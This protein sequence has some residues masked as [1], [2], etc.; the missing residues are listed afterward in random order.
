MRNQQSIMRN[1]LTIILLF[2]SLVSSIN[3]HSFINMH[4]SPLAQNTQKCIYSGLE[5]NS[6]RDY[7]SNIIYSNPLGRDLKLPVDRLAH[8]I[9]ERSLM[10]K[11]EEGEL[12]SIRCEKC[13]KLISY[14]NVLEYVKSVVR[15]VNVKATVEVA[16]SA[17]EVAKSAVKVSAVKVSDVKVNDVKV[18]DVKV[19]VKAVKV[20]VKV[21][22]DAN[23]EAVKVNANDEAVKVQSDSTAKESTTAS[24]STAKESTTASESTTTIQSNTTIQST[25]N[26]LAVK[27]FPA[28]LK[29]VR[30]LTFVYCLKYSKPEELTAFLEYFRRYFKTRPYRAIRRKLDKLEEI[31][32][33]ISGTRV[34]AEQW[35]PRATDENLN[36]LNE[37]WNGRDNE[38]KDIEESVNETVENDNG[39][40]KNEKETANEIGN[41]KS[42]EEKNQEILFYSHS[43][44]IP[45]GKPTVDE[46]LVAYLGSFSDSSSFL[47]S[48]SDSSPSGSS[49]SSQFHTPPPHSFTC[50]APLKSQAKINFVNAKLL[51]LVNQPYISH[52]VKFAY[53]LPYYLNLVPERYQLTLIR[54]YMEEFRNPALLKHV[55]EAGNYAAAAFIKSGAESYSFCELMILTVV[56]YAFIPVNK[57]IIY[58][59]I[60]DYVNSPEFNLSTLIDA[61]GYCQDYVKEKDGK[62]DNVN[63]GNWNVSDKNGNY[64]KGDNVSDNVSVKN[65][66]DNGKG[67]DN[68]DSRNE[69]YRIIFEYIVETVTEILSLSDDFDFSCDDLRRI[70]E[71]N[72]EALSPGLERNFKKM[73]FRCI[74]DW[75]SARAS[76]IKMPFS[77]SLQ[78]LNQRESLETLETLKTESLSQRESPSLQTPSLTKSLKM[79]PKIKTILN[80][81]IA[82]NSVEK[83]CDAVAVFGD[84]CL[85]ESKKELFLLIL[86]L[87]PLS[88]LRL[89][90]LT[91]F[92]IFDVAEFHFL[93]FTSGNLSRNDNSRN[94]SRNDNSRNLNRNHPSGN[95][96]LS[97]NL[98]RNLNSDNKDP[99]FTEF[100]KSDPGR[101]YAYLAGLFSHLMTLQFTDDNQKLFLTDIGVIRPFK[102]VMKELEN[103]RAGSG[104]CRS[105]DYEDSRSKDCEDCRSK[106]CE[107][108]RFYNGSRPRPCSCNG[109]GKD[110]KDSSPIHS[111][112]SP[113][114][115]PTSPSTFGNDEITNPDALLAY[116][117]ILFINNVIFQQCSNK[118][119]LI[120]DLPP[121]R[122]KTLNR[123]VQCLLELIMNFDHTHR[124]ILT[125]QR[126]ILILHSLVV[127]LHDLSTD[128]RFSDKELIG[129]TKEQA[130]IILNKLIWAKIKPDKILTPYLYRSTSLESFQNEIIFRNF[131]VNYVNI[132]REWLLDGKGKKRELERGGVGNERVS[133]SEL[134]GEG[135][136]ELEGELER[137]LMKQANELKEH[138]KELI[139]QANE[140]MSHSNE[141]MKQAN[142]LMKQANELTE[143]ERKLKNQN[144]EL[145]NQNKELKEQNELKNKQ[146]ELNQS[147][148]GNKIDE[149]LSLYKK[150]GTIKKKTT[151]KELRDLLNEVITTLIEADNEP[152]T[153]LIETD[154]GP[155][156][157]PGVD[158]EP[159]IFPEGPLQKLN[160]FL[161]KV[162][163]RGIEIKRTRGTRGAKGMRTLPIRIYTEIISIE[164]Y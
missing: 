92:A 107:D 23:D 105:K 32:K 75:S 134:E 156:M 29:A 53:Y 16:K 90:A 89:P 87:P 47:D 44:Y 64:G 109:N 120:L 138:D 25:S 122:E 133:K 101:Y 114:H 117:H 129:A 93:E 71:L 124:P 19:N 10:E 153:N 142:E 99:E 130:L 45:I 67:K 82:E 119:Y 102:S 116:A 1:P 55:H 40:V 52:E 21:Q 76:L 43:R 147:P 136:V 6:I 60:Y 100:I 4:F 85:V 77:G 69:K 79:S 34:S 30:P 57:S 37:I 163:E 7:Y 94:L 33:R 28:L 162:V 123:L 113:I 80:Q 22:S 91:K 2:I 39:T 151:L 70:D 148:L 125:F 12:L 24:E 5:P 111:H 161:L 11:L 149:I 8:L 144:K 31:I 36:E 104:H 83:F 145:K 20:N 131:Q 41:E 81:A 84:S 63:Y 49:P 98:S 35:L 95:K 118:K 46:D 73:K 160:E 154:N 78:T 59:R 141:L 68:V 155:E 42:Q 15:K 27:L 128:R 38:E 62:G 18:N 158:N 56:K 110:D 137:E 74:L 54:N 50:Y 127:Y 146:N 164:D 9:S 48:P 86:S 121:I 3:S 143:L 13:N 140:L 14:E 66:S 112:S 132:K 157:L 61:L 17:V 51:Y 26:A 150:E 103:W 97:K 126:P 72:Y 58:L 152:D 106:D 159:E 135:R 88:P 65:V 108:D 96:D 115:S 139:K